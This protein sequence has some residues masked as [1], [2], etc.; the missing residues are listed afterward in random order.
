MKNIMGLRAAFS[1]FFALVAAVA[2][3]TVAAPSARADYDHTSYNQSGLIVQYDGPDNG[4]NASTLVNLGSAGS[5]F[6]LALV[7]SGTGS[8]SEGVI[9]VGGAN[10]WS[11]SS[12][13]AEAQPT[14]GGYT[15]EFVGEQTGG[16]QQADNC[17]AISLDAGEL[18]S[19][20]ATPIRFSLGT[21]R[22]NR[23]SIQALV[24]A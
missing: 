24:N 16:S 2:F 4:A 22:T 5:A 23:F 21:M 14:N 18:T 7:A 3:C 17:V 12:P 20:V 13:V 8:I 15:V 9:T 6:N 11:M 10:S 19:A 1:A